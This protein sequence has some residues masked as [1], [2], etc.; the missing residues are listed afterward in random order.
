MAQM[1]EKVFRVSVLGGFSLAYGEQ[2]IVSINTVR[3]QSLLAYLILHA[4]T[5]Q[6]RQHVAF[7]LWPDTSESN[8]RN[9]LRQ[10]LHQLRQALPDPDRLLSVTAQTLCWQTDG[11]QIIDVQRFERALA[12]AAAADQRAD[13]NSAQQWLEEA[14]STYQGDLLPGC[15]DEWIT[16]ERDRL[17]QQCLAAHQKLVYLQE[18]QRDYPGALQVAQALLRL[19]PLDESTYITLMRLHDLNHDRPAAR[20][21]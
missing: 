21:V 18:Q 15:Y 11:D 16:P 19:D 10:F 9:N 2:S 13:W 3:L 20:R 7:L 1:P 8:A 17:R 5:P 4:D 12:N 14:L 6:P